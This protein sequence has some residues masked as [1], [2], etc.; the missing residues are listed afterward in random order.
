MTG[1]DMYYVNDELPVNVVWMLRST[2]SEQVKRTIEIVL[3]DI[4][5]CKD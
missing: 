5:H 2:R 3:V 4:T 1:R